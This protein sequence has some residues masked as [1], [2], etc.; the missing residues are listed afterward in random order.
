MKMRISRFFFACLKD[1]GARVKLRAEAMQLGSGHD[2]S[3]SFA[4]RQATAACSNDPYPYQWVIQ[5]PNS[6]IRDWPSTEG[7]RDA[8]VAHPYQR[9]ADSSAALAGSRRRA[10]SLRSHQASGWSGAD[11]TTG[12]RPRIVSLTPPTI[13]SC[14]DHSK[15]Y[16]TVDPVRVRHAFAVAPS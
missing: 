14:L 5:A 4:V 10:V 16:L 3:L 9:H 6:R 1:S 12:R 8:F 7:R 13:P 2:Y 15:T 11:F